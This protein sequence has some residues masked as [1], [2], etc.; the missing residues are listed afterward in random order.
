MG[1]NIERTRLCR[2]QVQEALKKANN[3]SSLIS[4]GPMRGRYVMLEDEKYHLPVSNRF[5]DLLILL[6]FIHKEA[7]TNIPFYLDHSLQR[8]YHL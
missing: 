6:S 8:N 3:A 2:L 5:V 7:L 1:S 4:I